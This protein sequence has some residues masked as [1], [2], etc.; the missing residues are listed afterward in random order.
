MKKLIIGVLITLTLAIIGGCFKAETEV[1]IN[2]DGSG[3]ITETVGLST[4]VIEMMKSAITEMFNPEG[5]EIEK[6]EESKE[7]PEENLLDDQRREKAIKKAEEMG[8]G[9]KF[10]SF[11]KKKDGDMICYTTVYYFEDINKVKLGFSS[12]LPTGPGSPLGR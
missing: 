12:E 2:P 10:V 5:K 11:G 8:E 7:E 3:T 9:V 4:Q 6:T 1:V